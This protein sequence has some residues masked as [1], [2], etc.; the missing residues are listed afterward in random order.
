MKDTIQNVLLNERL[1]NLQV[2]IDSINKLSTI[3]QLKYEIVQK[4]DIISQINEFYDSA[5]LKLT[6]WV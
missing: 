6:R 4:Q 3:R 5:W 2:S 1:N